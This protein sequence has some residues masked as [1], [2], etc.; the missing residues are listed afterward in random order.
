MELSACPREPCLAV[1]ATEGGGA[2]LAGATHQLST[3]QLPGHRHIHG[4][5]L[6][7]PGVGR[8]RAVADACVR[9]DESFD[10]DSLTALHGAEGKPV[11][12]V[13]SCQ[14]EEQQPVQREQRG[15]WVAL[16]AADGR[17]PDRDT[18]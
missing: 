1:G 15:V 13:L 4:G 6:G 3:N 9:G 10:L 8:R 18:T 12:L 7:E 14:L 17:P 5:P 16:R 2:G 11:P